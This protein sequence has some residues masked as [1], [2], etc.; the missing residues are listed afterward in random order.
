MRLFRERCGKQKET[1]YRFSYG[2]S[3]YLSFDNRFGST[4]R[5]DGISCTVRREDLDEESGSIDIAPNER[6]RFA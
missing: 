1:V 3:F 5:C 2:A 6:G 4:F